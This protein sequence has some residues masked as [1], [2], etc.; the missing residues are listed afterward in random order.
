MMR[1]QPRASQKSVS[2]LLVSSSLAQ[3]TRNTCAPKKQPGLNQ[4]VIVYV[5]RN[6]GEDPAGILRICL[7]FKQQTIGV[8]AVGGRLANRPPTA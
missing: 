5:T 1:V 6:P 7:N 2:D 8:F 3:E 4:R